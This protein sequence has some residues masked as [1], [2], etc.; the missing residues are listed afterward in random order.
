MRQSGQGIVSDRKTSE[1]VI[2]KI[3]RLD[4]PFEDLRKYREGRVVGDRLDTTTTV[5]GT[6]SDRKT[7]ESSIPSLNDLESILKT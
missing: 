5:P 3:P 1:S 4:K 7:S 6:V 2:S